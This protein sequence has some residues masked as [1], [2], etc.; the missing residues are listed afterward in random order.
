[1]Q[2][3]ITNKSKKLSD[4]GF[5]KNGLKS[6]AG[7]TRYKTSFL[8]TLDENIEIFNECIVINVTYEDIKK[9]K[10]SDDIIFDLSYLSDITYSHTEPEYKISK[11]ITEMSNS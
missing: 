1:M 8:F 9:R 3:W 4:Y 5:I 6:L 7:K 11:E 2:R 10:Y